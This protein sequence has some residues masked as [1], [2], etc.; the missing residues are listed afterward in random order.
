MCL[1][2]FLPYTTRSVFYGVLVCCCD[3]VYSLLL[4]GVTC[5]ID[6]ESTEIAIVFFMSDKKTVIAGVNL[7]FINEDRSR[8]F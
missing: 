8:W 3:R 6:E 5:A 1:C 7:F 2:I 4:G